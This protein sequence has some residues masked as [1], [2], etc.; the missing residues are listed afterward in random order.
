MRRSRA[1]APDRILGDEALRG[2]LR[3]RGL[4][5]AAE[6]TWEQTARA[7]RGVFERLKQGPMPMEEV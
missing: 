5:R 2:E 3:A 4:Q 1:P 7:T 6:L